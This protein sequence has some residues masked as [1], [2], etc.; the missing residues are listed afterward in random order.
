MRMSMSGWSRWNCSSRG[1]SHIEANDANV[2]N[3]TVRRPALWRIWRTAPSMRGRACVTASSSCEPAPVSSTAR[4]CRRN[5][6][7]PTSCSSAWIWRLTADWVS[8]SSSDAA[9]KFRCRATAS[10]ARR[11]PTEIGRVRNRAWGC[12]GVGGGARAGL[13]D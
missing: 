8:A 12:D 9:R 7:T 5:R 13:V 1:I 6:L 11:L 2:V 4:V 10:K 3:A